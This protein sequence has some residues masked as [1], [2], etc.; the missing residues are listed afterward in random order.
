MAVYDFAAGRA[1]FCHGR[2]R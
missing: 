1:R 2:A